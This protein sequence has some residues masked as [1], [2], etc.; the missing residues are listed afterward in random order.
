MPRRNSVT[1]REVARR[2]GVSIATVSYVLNESAPISEETRARVLAAAAELGYR[3]SAL[4]RSLRARQSH[5]IGYSWHHVPRDRWH[6]ILDPFLYSMAQAAEAEGYHILTFAQPTDGDP[7]RPYQE[8]MLTGRVDGFILSETNRNDPRVRYLLDHD[9]PFVAFGRANEEW[10]F[11]YVDVDNAAGTRM[12]VEHLVGLGHR[13]IAV[14]AWPEDSLTGSYRLQGYLEGMEAAGLP[15][16]PAWI[17]RTEHSE[18]AGRQAMEALLA[19]PPDRRPTAVVTM[20]D[21]MAIGA[22]NAL[23]EAGLQPG[24]DVSVV[25]FDD[26]PM[27]QYLHPPLTTLRQP[28]AEVGARVVEMLLKLI[29]GEPLP[30]R[31]VLLPPRLIVRES[32]GR[33]LEV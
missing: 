22:M 27:A 10:D 12:A 15:V 6:P 19:L 4:A 25:G 31:K 21:L 33:V 13:R 18:A 20:S 14:I 2:A 11:P 5:T 1:I 24:R 8:L 29:R 16:D 7:W 3:P 23:H 9:F 28:V 26:V 32:S 30:E 17:V